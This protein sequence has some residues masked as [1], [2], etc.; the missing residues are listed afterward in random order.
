MSDLTLSDGREIT[1]DLDKISIREYRAL[2][3]PKQSVAEEDAL[4]RAVSGLGDE[5][6][7][8]LSLNDQKRLLKA[9][10]KKA[11]AP[12]ADPN[13]AGASTTT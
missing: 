9:F 5:E 3:D 13:S 6:Y 4:I 10:L 8:G 1:F 11:R 12:L 2:F 7:L